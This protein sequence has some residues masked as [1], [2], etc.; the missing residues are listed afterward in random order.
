M[1][2]LNIFQKMIQIKSKIETKK[3]GQGYGYKYHQLEDI[4]NEYKPSALKFNVLDAFDLRYNDD[5]KHYECTITFINAD[6]PDDRYQVSMDLPLAKVKGASDA[7]CVGSTR[8]YA[9]RYM[10]MTA[11]GVAENDDPDAQKPEV[12]QE[13]PKKKPQSKKDKERAE[14]VMAN[15]KESAQLRK[16]IAELNKTATPEQIQKMKEIANG[17]DRDHLKVEQ[18][19]EI[20]ALFTLAEEI[21]EDIKLEPNPGITADTNPNN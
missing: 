8:T 7:Q 18:W 1:S 16:E 5:T 4:L 11:L 15:S 10:L 13:K 12:A 21:R 3:D 14:K 20:R 9:Y 6:K 19:R 2:D 17:V